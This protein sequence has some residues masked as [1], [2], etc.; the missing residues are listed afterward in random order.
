MGEG[1]KFEIGGKG[2]IQSVGN[3]LMYERE[4]DGRFVVDEGQTNSFD[5]DQQILAGYVQGARPLGP[6]QVQAGLRAELASRT[7]DLL[8]EVPNLTSVPSFTEDDTDQS[9]FSVFPSVFVTLPFGPGTLVKGSYSRRIN[10][11]PTFFLNPFPSYEDTTLI[12]VGN[13]GLDPEYTNSFDLTLQYKYF[14]TLTPYY[15]RTTDVISRVITAD[16]TTGNRIFTAR[17]AESEDSYGA[18]LTLAS[19]FL[20]GDLRGFLSGSMYRRVQT[21]A[22]PDL[23]TDGVS[24]NLRANAQMKLREG[25]EVQAFVFYNGPEK[26][27]G[28]ERE[29][30][31]FSSIGVNQ[32]IN[33]NLRL[34]A[35]VNDPF[36]LAKF[37]FQTAN[38]FAVTTSRFEPSI[39]QISATLTY[40]FGSNQNRPQVPQQQQPDTGGGFG[41]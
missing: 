26:I 34:S 16:T 3:D 10:R 11:P 9:Y 14:A 36:G 5:Y 33:D 23:V 7:F 32:K 41:F 38:R 19:Q 2:T 39:Q 29:A 31:I 8:T 40:T 37:E 30:F 6:V 21:D 15:R 24:W 28:G 27:A 20:G 17:N 12:R 1:G 13:P 25:T 4:V 35:R 18:D 22:D